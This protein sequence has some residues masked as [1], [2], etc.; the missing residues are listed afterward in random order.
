MRTSCNGLLWLL[1]LLG[2]CVCECICVCL[3][4]PL[5]LVAGPRDVPRHA[6][7]AS[8]RKMGWMTL[9]GGVGYCCCC[10][11][12][13]TRFD[14]CRCGCVRIVPVDCYRYCCY[15]G[16]IAV[17]RRLRLRCVPESGTWGNPTF[18]SPYLLPATTHEYW[19]TRDF[20][21]PTRN[22]QLETETQRREQRKGG[23][24]ELLVC[25][26]GTCVGSGDGRIDPSIDQS[27]DDTRWWVMYI[28]THTLTHTLTYLYIH[29]YK[30]TNTL[31]HTSTVT[32]ST[33]LGIVRVRPSERTS[34]GSEPGA[35]RSG[36]S[37]RGNVSLLRVL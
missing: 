19:I 37:F 22:Q 13:G 23:F 5:T 7:T 32:G 17:G 24:G 18:W 16:W 14:A 12:I 4:C 33:V 8:R 9:C 34:L 27:M 29:T 28:Q 20:Q 15:C 31:T 35:L 2:V 26:E 36:H 25:A 11:W 10:C 21:S 1:L 3:P 30:H 6:A